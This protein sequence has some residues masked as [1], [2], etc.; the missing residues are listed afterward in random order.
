MK[1]KRS[2]LTWASVWLALGSAALILTTGCRTPIEIKHAARAQVELT[3]AIRTAVSDLQKALT[4]FHQDTWDTLKLEGRIAI[5]QQAIASAAPHLTNVQIG[6]AF[7]ISNT[8]VRPWIDHA[9]SATESDEAIAKLRMRQQQETNSMI[10]GAYEIEIQD[11]ES[12][13]ASLPTPPAP[14]R[15]LLNIYQQEIS[16]EREQTE[17][18]KVVFNTLSAQIEFMGVMAK[19]V[20]AWLAVDVTISKEQVDSLEKSFK[21]AAQLFK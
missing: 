18:L 6:T 16:A 21:D 11:L 15:E 1:Q 8:K 3:G 17:K 7:E 12:D 9:F 5:A 10:K 20:D 14:I 4:S 2:H 19:T 13:K